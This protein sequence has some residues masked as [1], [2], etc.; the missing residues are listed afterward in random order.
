MKGPIVSTWRDV[1][2]IAVKWRQVSEPCDSVV[3]VD[4]LSE[5]EFKA[6][7]GSHTPMVLGQAKVVRYHPNAERYKCRFLIKHTDCPLGYLEEGFL[8]WKK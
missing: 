7:F 4:M 6:G 5:K 2:S 8:R 1:F 3:W